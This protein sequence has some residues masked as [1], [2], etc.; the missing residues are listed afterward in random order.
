M[1]VKLLPT[2]LLCLSLLTITSVGS[3]IAIQQWSGKQLISN[4]GGRIVAR[5][6]QAIKFELDT[7]IKT[8]RSHIM[9]IARH[10]SDD[11]L[12]DA[13]PGALFL[14]IK[15]IMTADPN[16][17]HIT[18]LDTNFTGLVVSRAPDQR[19]PVLRALG[20]E[21]PT[22]LGRTI[23]DGHLHTNTLHLSAPWFDPLT[24]QS[25]VTLSQEI[26]RGG[27]VI[28]FVQV[29]VA[30]EPLSAM[31]KAMSGST[32]NIIFALLDD[33]Y[34]LAHPLL[35]HSPVGF[36]P[37]AAL[38][39]RGDL[40]D[41]VLSVLDKA[42]PSPLVEEQ[43][44]DGAKLQNVTWRGKKY[45]LSTLQLRHQFGGHGVMI[46]TY[47]LSEEVD[48][49]LKDFLKALWLAGAVLALALIA[50]AILARRISHPIQRISDAANEVGQVEFDKIKP[51]GSSFIKEL[52]DLSHSFNAMLGG[53]KLFERYVPRSLVKKLIERGDE[54][55]LSEERVV[56]VMFTDIAGFTTLSEGL[57]ATQVADFINEHLTLLGRCVEEQG[58]T[59]DKYIGDSLMAFWGAP[60]DMEDHAQAACRAAI[61]IAADLKADNLRR[62]TNGLDPVRIRVGIHTGPLVV[63]DIGSPNRINYTIMGDTV[64]V[65]ARLEALGKEID[66]D[67]EII[68]LTGSETARL[69]GGEFTLLQEGSHT[70]RGKTEATK[71]SRLVA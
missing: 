14:F 32:Q 29:A 7:Y 69:A 47:R 18:V 31:A 49:M 16:V 35:V 51:L 44:L 64:N 50:A 38:P 52:H 58:G 46:G 26:S 37:D 5:N 45:L 60:D 3:V 25:V 39:L 11:G 28:A 6:L 53:L 17:V 57:T 40:G 65:A 27:A 55:T 21:D 63:G 9:S 20:P 34:V 10:I 36:S 42:V 54:H 13:T 2:F 66:P 62:R 70:V 19:E 30:I 59:I 67:A 12:I 4:L 48:L 56:T 68:I 23:S 8:N 61:A 15:G 43:F 24:A 33:Q 1:K 71:V 22:S 41:G